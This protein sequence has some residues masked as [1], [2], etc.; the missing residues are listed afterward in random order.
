MNPWPQTFTA[1]TAPP[2]MVALIAQLMNL[3]LAGEDSPAAVLREQYAHARL[4][5]LTL[6]GAGFFADFDV[7]SETRRVDPPRMV[8]G[9]AEIDI[10]GVE[11]A[12]GCVLFVGE[13]VIQTLEGYT[14]TDEWP[15][16]PRVKAIRNI[17]PLV[18]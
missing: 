8:G 15:I 1:S 17:V 10:E 7:P 11:H 3:I 9:S 6:T 5:E 13:G 2:E 18:V 16:H 14:Y 12:A 4:A